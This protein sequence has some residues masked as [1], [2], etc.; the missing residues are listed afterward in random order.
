MIECVTLETSHH[1]TGN[2]ISA[3]HKLRFE[4]IIKRQNWDVPTV[5]DL[6]FDA[7]DNPA[8]YYLVKRNGNCEA[9]ASSRLYPTERPY[10]LQQSFS[11]LVTKREMPSDPCVWEG[12]RFCI[13]A[14][15]EP[16]ERRQLARELVVGYLEFALHHRIES[17]IGVMYPVYWKNLFIKSGWDVEWLGDVHRSD[18]GHKIIAGDLKVSQAVLDHVRA[19][20]G[21][22]HPVLD[23]GSGIF[24]QRAAA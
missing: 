9:V 24:D 22:H 13:K 2:P 17:I 19:I 11:H 8:A 14:S 4:S 18:E 6:E 20:T 10:M 15:L 21:I 3:Q 7:Y 5:R 16:E 1:F 23:L 12:S